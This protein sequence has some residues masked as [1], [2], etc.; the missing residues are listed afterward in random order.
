MKPPSISTSSC[1][2]IVKLSI[3]TK[4]TKENFKLKQH[5]IFWLLFPNM[6]QAKKKTQHPRF[7]SVQLNSVFYLTLPRSYESCSL[8]TYTEKAF[9]W[10]VGWLPAGCCSFSSDCEWRKRIFEHVCIRWYCNTECGNYIKITPQPSAAPGCLSY[11]SK[12]PCL[13]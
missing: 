11:P 10:K 2:F 3:K 13:F 12:C 5:R 4:I 1:L 7:P 8:G 9:R 6:G